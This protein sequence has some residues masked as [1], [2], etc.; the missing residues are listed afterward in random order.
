MVSNEEINGRGSDDEARFVA[1]MK[2]LREQR[3]WSQ[4]ELARRMAESGW[5][6]FHQTTISRIEKGERPVRLGEAKGIAT[7]LEV[8]VARML[9]PS[10][11]ANLL[12][13]LSDALVQGLEAGFRLGD[14][15][16]NFLASKDWIAHCLREANDAGIA[17]STDESIQEQWSDLKTRAEHTLSFSL[18]DSITRHLSANRGGGI[19][20][21]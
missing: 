20:D 16:D 18:E 21:G 1:S 12:Q 6:G 2:R 9:I 15:I 3:G 14:A 4:G 11:E 10:E 17:A 19:A 8:P 13:N 7:L 5:D